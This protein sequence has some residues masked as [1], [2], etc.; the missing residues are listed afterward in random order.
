MPNPPTP[1]EIAAE[2][3]IQNIVVCLN[4]SLPPPTVQT[5]WGP[6]YCGHGTARGGGYCT[7]CLMEALL[8]TLE[9]RGEYP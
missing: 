6:A 4:R 1:A 7:G 8:L 5:T 3:P 9:A 2:L